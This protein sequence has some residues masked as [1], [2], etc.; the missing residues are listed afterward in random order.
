VLSVQAP[1]RQATAG[2]NKVLNRLLFI[3]IHC[4]FISGYF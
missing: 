4:F 3:I 2:M 1:S